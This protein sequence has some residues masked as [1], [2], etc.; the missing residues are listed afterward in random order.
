MQTKPNFTMKCK[1]NFFNLSRQFFRNSSI[2]LLMTAAILQV[3]ELEMD[4]VGVGVD[5]D[6]NL[7]IYWK[8]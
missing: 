1:K 8:F 4:D 6:K 2:V 7:G 5:S 3:L